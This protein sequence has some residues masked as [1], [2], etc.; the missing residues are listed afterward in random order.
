MLTSALLIEL[1]NRLFY[2]YAYTYIMNQ[3]RS[4]SVDSVLSLLYVFALD[5]LGYVVYAQ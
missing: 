3:A 1:F 5:C 2:I 4:S